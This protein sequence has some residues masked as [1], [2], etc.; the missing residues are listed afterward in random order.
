M[1]SKYYESKK[2][3][4]ATNY[5][6]LNVSISP[7][8]YEAFQATCNESGT[9]MRRTIVDFISSKIGASPATDKEMLNSPYGNRP[10]RRKAVNRVTKELKMIR[11]AE[12]QYMENIPENLRNSARFEAVEQS[13]ATLDEAIELL[14]G[15]FE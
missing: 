6:Q 9:S 2:R 5:R 8:V 4:N 13:I 11:E 7:S 15:V 3:W 10:K 1:Q 14:E 12:E